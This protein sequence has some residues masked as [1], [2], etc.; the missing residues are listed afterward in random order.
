MANKQAKRLRI[1]INSNA[2][3]GTSGYS[4][5]MA[6]LEPRIAAAGYP[7]ATIDYFGLETGKINFGGVTH[8][9]KFRHTYGSDGMVLHGRDHQADVV[10]SLCDQWVLHPDDLQQIPRWIPITPIDHDP[11]PQ[12][13]LANL[14]FAYRI[15]TYSLFGQDQ[16]RKQGIYS[17]YIPHTVDTSIFKPFG[18]KEKALLK[19]KAGIDPT[20][21]LFGMVAA[22]KDNPP[23]KSFQEVMDAFKRFL[24]VQPNSYLY[25]HTNP[26]FPGGFPLQAY[27]NF[28]GIQQRFL[29]PDV[30]QMNFNM[31]KPEMAKVY[32]AFDCLLMPSISEGFGVP[33]IEAQACGVPVI[34]NRFTAMPELVEEG[35]TGEICEVAYKRF[36]AAQSYVGVPSVDS[37]FEK[38]MKIYKTD[39]AK[40]GK[41]G[42]ERMVRYYDSNRI[43]AEYWVPFLADLES[44]IYPSIDKSQK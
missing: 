12:N 34:V 22:N 10:F 7:L 2:S 32:N 14:R 30:Y 15:I 9:G 44:E 11:V 24:T 36:S 43:F 27:A 8:Y 1:I 28:L 13:V 31:G 21:F 17:T 33:A 16:L 39:R 18:E 42:F 38:M 40:M 20:A 26:E 5:Q 35:V 19:A 29:T 41:R 6:E 25:I 37:L 3:F 23:R 4:G